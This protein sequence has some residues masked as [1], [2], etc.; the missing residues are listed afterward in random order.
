VVLQRRQAAR[1][2]G[3]RARHQ[4]GVGLHAQQVLVQG[5]IEKSGGA[6]LASA[7]QLCF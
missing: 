5:L 4:R 1:Q 2:A 7:E 3:Q 6:Y